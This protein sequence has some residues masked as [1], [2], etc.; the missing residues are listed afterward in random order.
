MKKPTTL[1]S[2]R[3]LLM[4]FTVT[5]FSCKKSNEIPPFPVSETEF[6]QPTRKSIDFSEVD[7]IMW[8]TDTPALLKSFP[9]K[10]FSWNQLPE[11]E[12]D[13]GLP[14]P[15]TNRPEAKPFRLDSLESRPFSYDSLPKADLE[16]KI[17]ELGMPEIF[18]AGDLSEYP[19]ATRG[20]QSSGLAFGLPGL[21]RTIFKD[22]D[23]LLWIGTD[24]H[25]IR[26]DSENFEVYGPEQGLRISSATAIFED[27][28]NRLWV[29]GNFGEVA[30]I[31]FEANIIY[32]LS[33]V[34]PTSGIYGILESTD[35]KFWL[36]SL[37]VGY[38][39]FDIED[40]SVYQLTESSGLAGN[41]VITPYQDKD[42]LIW[43]SSNRGAN[44]IDLNAGK[45]RH[46][47]LG[48][49]FPSRFCSSFREDNSGNLWISTGIGPLVLNGSRSTITTYVNREL[50]DE[51]NG[52][53]SVFQDSGGSIWLGGNNGVFYQIK[54][55]TNEVQKYTVTD[56]PSRAFLYIVED[57]QGQI[58][59]AMPQGGLY[60]INVNSG[61]PGNF[62]E[63]DG[64]SSNA[65][66]S[67]LETKDGKI[68]IGTYE[69]IDIYDPQTRAIKHLGAEHGLVG[70]RNARLK[71]DS[72]GRVWSVGGSSGV[73][74]IDPVKETIQQLSSFQGLPSDLISGIVEG[75]DG[76][77]WM[78]ASEGELIKLNP[79]TRSL[80]HFLPKQPENVFQNNV[81][82]EDS[83]ENIW[84]A[85][86]GSGLQRINTKTNERLFIRL[87]DGLISNT[88]YAITLDEKDNIWVATDLGVQYLDVATKEA[89][90]FTTKEGLAANDVYAL[91]IYEGKLY[92]G[93]SRGLTILK[94]EDSSNGIT[95]DIKKIGSEQGLRLLDFSENSFTFDKNNRFWA[96]VQGEMLTVM[97]EISI[98]STAS[99]TFLTGINILDEEQYFYDVQVQNTLRSSLDTIWSSNRTDYSV[100]ETRSGNTEKDLEIN[101][102]I[103]RSPYNIPVGL[104]LPYTQNFLSFRYNAA[105]YAN[106]DQ[107]Y[108]RY[109]LEGIDKNWSPI[110]Q[111]TTS[112][113][114]RDLPPG[115]YTFR[116]A[117]KGF[118]DVW[119][120]PSIFQFTIM[121]PWW[122]TW[123]AYLLFLVVGV[124]AIWSFISYRS[125]WLKK[126]NRLLE[127]R[128]S[129]RTEQ[130]KK[131]I[132]ELKAT[133]SQ[134]IQSE[135][136]ASLGE[137]TAGIAHEI[138]NPLNFVNNFSEVN[139]ELI[140]EMQE[141][142]EKEDYEEVLALAKDIKANQEKINHH[143]KRADAIVKGMLQH[144]RS[145]SN[146]KVPSNINAI[147][148][149]YLRLAYH[150]LRAKDKSFNA[151]METDF[152]SSIGKINIVPQDVGRVIL[153]L[154]TNAFHAVDERRL[155]EKD[156]PDS[157]YKPTVLVSSKRIGNSVEVSIKDNGNGIPDKV[158]DKIFQPFFTTK[159]SGQGTGLGLSLSYDIIKAHGGMLLLDTKIGEGTTF[160]ITLPEV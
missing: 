155:K 127:E 81:I 24:G 12:V 145:S 4:V 138:Q 132:E 34:F 97:D 114:Y 71:L 135:K 2:I 15:F 91:K 49:E 14:L 94:P 121:P 30:I 63:D 159:P 76:T 58:W 45:N 156:K 75:K 20:V 78:G 31:D 139:T 17:I 73:S 29:G 47:F 21:P 9:V 6:Q 131:K 96:G 52:T 133:Q 85:G 108:Y 67:T 140:D 116:V 33:S 64:L 46:L 154:I 158:R 32:E 105:N 28:K 151:T 89:I 137:L 152:D 110:T 122:K 43:L 77:I 95:W 149:E 25:I 41:Y 119:S 113:N 160:T 143:G 128:V 26:Y 106:R 56:T 125:N 102:D 115:E 74:I 16:I 90:T 129:H 107:I 82:I 150:G 5:I 18:L 147:A 7:T 40:S 112:E 27:S 70:D 22:K 144:S 61:R 36:S 117:S 118:N 80:M 87:D 103:V 109:I 50:F 11:K 157:D 23:S 51:Q 44:I 72:Q 93:T 141:E 42:G 120:E 142:L 54:N 88:V 98:D 35:G 124:L 8:E 60:R 99:T 62:T 134:L 38:H 148:D 68:W 84:I 39:I 79:E 65:I 37:N 153:N 69:G 101:W 66:W 136:M 92:A 3:L 104:R 83:K 123:W 57:K 53:S 48:D 130:L 1:I 10:R 146:E 86:I 100:P 13:F 126:E 111:E 59:G 55:Q 19:G